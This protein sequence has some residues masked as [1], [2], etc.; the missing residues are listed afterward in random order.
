MQRKP[1]RLILSATITNSSFFARLYDIFC[2]VVYQTAWST[3]NCWCPS[4]RK[5]RRL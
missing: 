3:K 2:W 1:H 5:F 4:T